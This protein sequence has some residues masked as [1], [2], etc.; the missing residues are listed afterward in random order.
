LVSTTF[1]L[2]KN[3][4]SYSAYIVAGELLSRR[5]C[6]VGPARLA[7]QCATLYL[8]ILIGAHTVLSAQKCPREALGC[9][10]VLDSN[11]S[12]LLAATIF[13]LRRHAKGARLGAQDNRF[14]M[15]L[16]EKGF[17]QE[18]RLLACS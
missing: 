9:L 18:V 7:S 2:S 16:Q 13:E 15:G 11:S 17:S 10:A 1:L 3:I 14:T 4:L 8:Y 12:A 6:S 5:S